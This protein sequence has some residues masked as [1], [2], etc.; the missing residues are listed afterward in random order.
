MDNGTPNFGGNNDGSDE[1]KDDS[2]NNDD[3][4]C[5]GHDDLYTTENFKS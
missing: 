3:M 5:D 4:S 1:E 2:G